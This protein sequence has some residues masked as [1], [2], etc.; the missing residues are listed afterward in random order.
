M[1]LNTD[2]VRGLNRYGPIGLCGGGLKSKW[3]RDEIR[4]QIVI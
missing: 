3:A 4:I 2:L 1:I